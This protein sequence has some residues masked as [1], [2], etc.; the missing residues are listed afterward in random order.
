MLAEINV[1][2]DEKV[3]C[4]DYGRFMDE[5]HILQG[6]VHVLKSN[7]SVQVDSHSEF[8]SMFKET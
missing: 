8:E 6:A 5:F 7:L 3:G 4:E 2:I 1:R